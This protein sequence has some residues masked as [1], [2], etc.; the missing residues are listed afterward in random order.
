[1]TAASAQA[2][3]PCRASPVTSNAISN[4]LR[5]L[6]G[7]L[8]VPE[9]VDRV[10][11]YQSL[12]DGQWRRVPEDPNAFID[13]VSG[14]ELR[15]WTKAGSPSLEGR[16][17][18]EV[19]SK[20]GDL[21]AVTTKQELLFSLEAWGWAGDQLK[22]LGGFQQ[23]VPVERLDN[24]GRLFSADSSLYVCAGSGCPPSDI[25]IGW[26]S[27]EIEVARD[28][29][30][31]KRQFLLRTDASGWDGSIVWQMATMPFG[32]SFDPAPS[33]LVASGVSTGNTF[34]I[35]FAHTQQHSSSAA[36]SPVAS[37]PTPP[38]A[39]GISASRM[40]AGLQ[41]NGLP[42]REDS[43]LSSVFDYDQIHA[44]GTGISSAASNL[45]NNIPATYY[46]RAVPMAG[47]LSVAMPSNSIVIHHV[48]GSKDDGVQIIDP[49]EKL[50]AI[51]DVEMLEF[52]TFNPSSSGCAKVI[53]N[54]LTSPMAT[55][56]KVGSVYCPPPF[57]GLGGKHWYEMLLDFASGGVDWIAN[58]YDGV[59]G[60]V[61]DVVA[62]AIPLC[63]DSDWCKG[64]LSA[65]LDAAL[66]AAGVPPSLPSFAELE[67]MGEGYLIDYVAQQAGV[68]CG[69]WSLCQ[70]AIKSAISQKKQQALAG[71]SNE[72]C[73]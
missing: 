40:G 4:S 57:K 15:G 67:G 39:G 73:L 65:G 34:E 55:V 18:F 8:L 71:G 70:D 46:V 13:P 31:Q 45:L 24:I 41:Q 51:F 19:A 27:G 5:L 32:P 30:N 3:A 43:P 64:V 16:R 53:R 9:T 22:Y 6:D 29:P 47:S 20:L 61:V 26:R 66:V 59:K 23:L 69:P 25:S 35:D 48:P 56:Y 36:P 21:R 50:P 42:S 60:F 68:D 17:V 14:E 52:Q 72:A 1:M 38:P 62:S 63:S 49:N 28:N 58:A 7:K 12:G 2:R 11:Y 44:A 54:D 33:G 37:S 10:Y